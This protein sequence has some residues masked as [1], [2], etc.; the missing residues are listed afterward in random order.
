MQLKAIVCTTL[1]KKQL[2]DAYCK[3]TPNLL[4][5]YHRL[6]KVVLN[7]SSLIP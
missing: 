1:T 7:F 5:E 6:A 4:F 2:R 3:I